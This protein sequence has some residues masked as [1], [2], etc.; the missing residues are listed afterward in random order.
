MR[1]P[2]K[3]NLHVAVGENGSRKVLPLFHAVCLWNRLTGRS[4]KQRDHV[5]SEVVSR[6]LRT[7]TLLIVLLRYFGGTPASSRTSTS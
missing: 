4:L 1:P 2:A 3:I 7:R 6:F 5:S